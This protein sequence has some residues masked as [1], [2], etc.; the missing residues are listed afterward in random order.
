MSA[1]SSSGRNRSTSVEQCW[2]LVGARRGRIWCLR[3]IDPCRGVETSVRFDGMGV[4]RREEVRRDVMGFFHTHPDGPPRPSARDIRTM[5]AWCSAFGKP[6]LC[7]IA[8]PLGLTAFRFANDRSRGA[9]VALVEL[10]PRGVL[11]GVEDDAR[12]VPS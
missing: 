10:F 6:L 8:S 11:V 5:R 2:T 3:R 1:S 4:L 12:Q 9:P 7:V